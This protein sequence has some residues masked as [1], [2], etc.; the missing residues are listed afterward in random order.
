MDLA[1]LRDLGLTDG[2]IKVYLATLELGSATK[3]PIVE[4]AGVASSKVYELLDKLVQ[5][6]LVSQV[7]RSGVRHYESAPPDRL[8]DYAE[9]K[10]LAVESQQ[11][12]VKKLI[13][14]LEIARSLAGM[15]SE[16]QVFKGMEGGRTAFG[17]ILRTLKKGDEYAVIG[18]SR[19]EPAFERFVVHFHEDRA[20]RGIRCTVI[21]NELAR[22][23]GERLA[24]N[25][26]TK[27][28][29]VGADLFTPVVF[30]VYKDKTLISI[31]LDQVF[32]Q[33]R[34]ANLAQG[35]NAYARHLLSIAKK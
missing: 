13:P 23:V 33:V 32:I 26:L 34:S 31:S 7:V 17:D 29:Y 28:A 35:L 1:P 4:R 30:I 20:S 11:A 24:K 8:L 22:D 3:G 16:T 15:G 27:V 5:K 19:F 21:V 9:E 12:A 2:E 25:P 10:R 14:Q 6:G 18:I